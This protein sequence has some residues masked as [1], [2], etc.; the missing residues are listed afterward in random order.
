MGVRSNVMVYVDPN[1]HTVYGRTMSEQDF[2]TYLTWP[3]DEAVIDMMRRIG[4]SWVV[5]RQSKFAES[6][7]HET[8]LR[9]VYGKRDAHQRRI[10]ESDRFCRVADVNKT[11]L[12][13]IG[14][15]EGT[16]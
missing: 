2:V 12:Y 14:T 7:Y 9:P 6:K 3:S 5:V 1:L 10:Y 13:R 16:A 11:I 8:W 4:V 15:C